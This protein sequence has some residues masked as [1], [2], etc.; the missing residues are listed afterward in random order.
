MFAESL[1]LPANP[2]DILTAALDGPVEN[3]G[4]RAMRA[5]LTVWDD[6]AVHTRGIVL[7][8]TAG[9]DTAVGEMLRGFI[10]REITHRVALAVPGPDAELRAGLVASQIVGVLFARYGIRLASVATLSVDQI[11][12]TV[13]PTLQRYLTGDVPGSAGDVVPDAG[14]GT[15]AESAP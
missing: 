5:V 14:S 11:V 6:P 1:R 10:T 2:G 9:S 4:E 8:R 12:G 3:M 7:V 15:D 13:G